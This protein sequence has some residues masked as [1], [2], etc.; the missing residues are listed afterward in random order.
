MK[1]Q[2]LLYLQSISFEIELKKA[3]CSFKMPYWYQ[4]E[5]SSIF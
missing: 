1:C 2:I 4:L 5:I 3:V